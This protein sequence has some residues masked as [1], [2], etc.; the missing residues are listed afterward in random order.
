MSEILDMSEVLEI[1]TYPECS[2]KPDSTPTV[3]DGN[4]FDYIDEVDPSFRKRHYY[5][6]EWNNPFF[7]KTSV[8]DIL[9]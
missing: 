4:I 3:L 8:D 2:K 5:V 1:V 9:A 7:D 6:F